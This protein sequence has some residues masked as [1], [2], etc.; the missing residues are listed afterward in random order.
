MTTTDFALDEV[1]PSELAAWSAVVGA[2]PIPAAVVTHLGDVLA[3]N[4]WLDV[5]PGDR[6]L[7][8]AIVGDN[9]TLRFGVDQTRY[10]VR[11][12]DMDGRFLLATAEREDA[13]DHLLRQFFSSGDALFVVY[14][15]AGLIIQSNAAWEKLLGYTS[16]QVFGL[17]SWS[18]LPDSDV[19]TR[20]EVELELRQRGRAETDF[21]MRTADGSYRRVRWALQFDASVGRCFGIGRDVTEEG[22]ITA[23]L[24]R[25]AFHDQL[26][27]LNN[28]SLLVDRLDEVLAQGAS[29]SL[30][31][32][33]LDRFKVVNDSLGHQAGD[34]LLSKIA[35]RIGS[36]DLGED[37][38]LARF[39]GDEFVVLVESGGVRRARD[40]AAQLVDS[41]SE[42]FDVSGRSLHV[43]MS[44]GISSA[45]LS[46]TRT[47]KGLLGDADTAAYAAKTRGRARWVVFDEDLRSAAARRLDV[48]VGLR[49]ALAEGCIEPFFQPIVTLPDAEVVGV[50]ALV[51]WRT[52]DGLISPG[53]FLDVADDAGLMPELGRC[54]ITGAIEAA[55]RLGEFDRPFVMSINVADPELKAPGFCEWIE[56]EV[57]AAGLEPSTFLIEITESSVLATD[58]A[59][60][61]LLRLRAAG[62]RIGLDDFG[63]GF[64][65]LAHLRELPIDV[66]KVDRSFVA[67]LVDDPVTRAVT[68]SLVTLCTALGLHVVLE[69]IE[70]FEQATAAE[71]IGGRSAQG[72]LFHRPMSIADLIEL[73]TVEREG[74]AAPAVDERM[75]PLR[76]DA[77]LG[78]T[79]LQRRPAAQTPPEEVC[80][81]A[82]AVFADDGGLVTDLPHER[83]ARPAGPG[84]AGQPSDSL[85][86]IV[87]RR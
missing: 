7:D 59:V 50:E 76:L 61:V 26:T 42:P 43:T 82:A 46:P 49:Q 16:D 24:E 86:R 5:E 22:K 64:S 74:P 60:P 83:T 80:A 6:L 58:P 20:P 77:H 25:R 56:E 8:A 4:R 85:S 33:D 53:D 12:V 19:I 69:G 41:L 38:L 63:T 32:C 40:V 34:V 84:P 10:R 70:T 35:A 2:M 31:F 66:V 68:E 18:L 27:G 73:L 54:V 14:D 1:A 30:L 87:R 48:E 29:P 57:R 17:D 13:G 55:A 44:I 47:A 72:Y 21:Q 36:V 39:G 65:S 15:Q 71:K 75:E 52:P 79:P 9:S 45:D 81:D 51:R 3:T 78:E 28:R 67:D 62:F 11:P 37:A 23:E